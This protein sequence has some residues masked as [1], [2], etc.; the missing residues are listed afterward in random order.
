LSNTSVTILTDFIKNYFNKNTDLISISDKVDNS[1]ALEAAINK[2]F[3]DIEVENEVRN[4]LWDIVYHGRWCFR[5]VW[6][7][8]QRRYIKSYLQHP[9][10]VVT[11]KSNQR[12]KCHLVTSRDNKIFEVEPDSIFTIGEPNLTLINDLNDNYFDD[13]DNKDTLLKEI[14]LSAGTPLY[15]NIVGLVKE[16]L[17]KEQILTL[18]SI[19][20][21]IQPLLLLINVDKGTSP[22]DANKLALNTENL[23]NKYSDISAILSSNFG[24]NDLLDSIL[25]NIR[26]LPDYL[27]AINN[28]GDLD[29]TKISNKIDSIRS[30]QDNLKE[31]INLSMSIPRSLYAGDSTKWDAIKSSQRLNSRINSLI[32]GIRDSLCYQAQRYVYLTTGKVYPIRYFKCNI[33]TKTDVDYNNSINNSEIINNLLDNINRVMDTTQRTLQDS[34]LIDKA[35]YAKYVVGQLEGIDNDVNTFVTEKTINNYIKELEKESESSE[36]PY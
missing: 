23:I 13:K 6:D 14:E 16:Y 27:S 24:I 1:K 12:V 19:K 20:D 25:N 11:V 36:S 28:M 15:Y 22:D 29:L 7:E 18:L 8:K 32:D 2:I 26:V 17:L 21:L 3:E 5:S 31:K 9:H 10:S 35:G 30:D 33:F 34:K 4:H